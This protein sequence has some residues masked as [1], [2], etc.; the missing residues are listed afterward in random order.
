MPLPPL[1]RVFSFTL[2]LTLLV[3]GCAQP[4]TWPVSA[5]PT[6]SAQSTDAAGLA[7]L[8]DRLA[9]ESGLVQD[10]G[11]LVTVQPVAT[12]AGEETLFVSHTHGFP[13]DNPTVQTKSLDSRRR[14]GGLEGSGPRGA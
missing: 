1:R 4:V 5:A 13:P 8:A 7:Q 2:L 3:A 9:A 11:P 6:A 12:A 10:L 14:P